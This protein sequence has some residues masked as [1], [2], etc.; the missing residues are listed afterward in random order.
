MLYLACGQ[1]ANLDAV[2]PRV[3]EGYQALV[4]FYELLVAFNHLA[5]VVRAYALT[6]L[7]LAVGPNVLS[8]N[9]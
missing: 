6:D 7:N 3:A 2:L 1:I 5:L 4:R 9:F 8:V